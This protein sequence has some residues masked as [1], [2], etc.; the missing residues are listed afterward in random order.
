MRVFRRISSLLALLGIAGCQPAPTPAPARQS[1]KLA[2]KP[3][4]KFYEKAKLGESIDDVS[5]GLAKCLVFVP[6]E[7]VHEKGKPMRFKVDG[8]NR[9][10]DLCYFYTDMP[11]LQAAFPKGTAYVKMR[12][13]SVFR[14]IERDPHFGGLFI[15]HTQEYRYLFPR[16]VFDD[17]RK[18][19]DSD[20]SWEKIPIK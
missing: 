19:L 16:E 1:D 17:V 13:G 12:F 8:D 18:V 14:V 4:I 9:G 7:G 10:Q 3:L 6:T 15:N 5:R 2:I 11:E 20:P